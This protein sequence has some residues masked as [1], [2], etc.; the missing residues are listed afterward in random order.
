MGDVCIVCRYQSLPFP[1]VFCLFCF[2]L[3]LSF[4]RNSLTAVWHLSHLQPALLL[5][6]CWY[7]DKVLGKGNTVSSHG[8]ISVFALV[9]LIV[10]NG[11]KSPF[12]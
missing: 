7:G 5:E 2:G 1:L 3:V 8:E 4:L 11:P 9:V 12:Y 6:S 10:F